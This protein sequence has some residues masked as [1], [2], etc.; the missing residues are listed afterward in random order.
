MSDSRICKSRR[1]EIAGGEP[2][3][4]RQLWGNQRANLDAEPVR[5]IVQHVHETG[6]L[7]LK[8]DR[9]AKTISAVSENQ[10]LNKAG[11]YERFF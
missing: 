6:K 3:R 2:K 8:G 7:A 1:G 10:Q 11:Y 5:G 9:F 4:C